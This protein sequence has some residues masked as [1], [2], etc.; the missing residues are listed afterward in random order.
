[1]NINMEYI[2][3]SA[4]YGIQCDAYRV[5]KRYPRTYEAIR[6][7]LHEYVHAY[8]TPFPMPALTEDWDW[9][10]EN[11][12]TGFMILTAFVKGD[13]GMEKLETLVL[14]DTNVYIMNET[15]S[16]VDTLRI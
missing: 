4:R 14:Q 3:A 16:T 15:G 7:Y 2:P 6:E 10:D 11:D 12:Y 9:G 5:V 13:H 8:Y 1:M